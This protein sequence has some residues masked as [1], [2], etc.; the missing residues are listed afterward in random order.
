VSSVFLKGRP[1]LWSLKGHGGTHVNGLQI[2]T[3]KG[4]RSVVDE[5]RGLMW[6]SALGYALLW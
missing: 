3:D 2:P 6:R 5:I 4:S 1:W